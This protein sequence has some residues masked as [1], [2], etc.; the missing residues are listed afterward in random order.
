MQ[1]RIILYSDSLNSLWVH[2]HDALRSLS[3]TINSLDGL[4]AIAFGSFVMYSECTKL[5]PTRRSQSCCRC[6]RQA[7]KTPSRDKKTL[8]A[9]NSISQAR[10]S[11]HKINMQ[12]VGC[13]LWYCAE[14]C[15][16]F[17]HPA[18]I[19]AFLCSRSSLHSA[20][21]AFP[22]GLKIMK[23]LVISMRYWK[24]SLS[25]V[26][27]PFYIVKTFFREL[28]A[29]KKWALWGIW[30]FKRPARVFFM[31]FK[32]CV[33]WTLRKCLRFL[34]YIRDFTR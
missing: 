8:H 28:S 26:C 7:N 19:T 34:G 13:S 10:V 17:L 1:M 21:A 25:R 24:I 2:F 27:A 18:F 9:A 23:S 6:W 31:N 4:F 15:G 29:L 22:V 16:F 12:L 32:A 11:Q 5:F 3:R 30:I 14:A 20:N 33:F